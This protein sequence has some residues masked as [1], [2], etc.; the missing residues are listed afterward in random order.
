VTRRFAMLAVAGLAG[1]PQPSADGTTREDA[2]C[3]VDADCALL[4]S[5]T[6]CGE[7]PPVP[8]F[9]VGARFNLDAI[10][11][12]METRCAEDRRECTPPVCEPM[13]AGCH[14]SAACEAGRCVVE[15]D[16]CGRPIA[17]FSA[18]RLHHARA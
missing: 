13:P 16:G 1:C 9:D 4:P 7:C 2:E 12:E 10:F 3:T 6:C 17:G 15:T 14:A 5:V 18:H 11:I 8:P